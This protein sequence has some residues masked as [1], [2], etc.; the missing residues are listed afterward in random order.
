MK[1]LIALVVTFSF[2][3][4]ACGGVDTRS[5]KDRFIS[6]MSEAT[7]LI[8]ELEMEEE[9]VVEEKIKAVFNKHGFDIEDEDEMMALQA[10]YEHLPEVEEAIRRA[11]YDCAPQEFIDAMEAYDAEAEFMFEE[12]D[13]FI[14]VEEEEDEME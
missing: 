12:E 7:C 13:E 10:K 5:E 6:A 14:F 1:K 8:F 2:V 11:L 4:A 3:L 9:Q